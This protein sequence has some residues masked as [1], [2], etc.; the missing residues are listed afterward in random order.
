MVS[1]G[2]AIAFCIIAVGLAATVGYLVF[3]KV[4]L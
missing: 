1:E 3:E 4:F 2:P